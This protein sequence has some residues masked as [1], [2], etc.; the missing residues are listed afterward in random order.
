MPFDYDAIRDTIETRWRRY[1]Y[2]ALLPEER[3]YL[4]VWWLQAEASNGSLHQYFDNSTG[5]AALDTLNALRRRN[6]PSAASVL[7]DSIEI[8]SDG[9][10]PTD[11]LKRQA[12]INALESPYDKFAALTDRLFEQSEDVT[13]LAIDRVGVAYARESINVAEPSA[14]KPMR[15][16]A[17]AL[18]LALGVLAIIAIVVLL[19]SP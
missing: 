5:D 6:A 8:V 2:D 18:L 9:D 14:S 10:Y 11:R 17:T 13:S 19:F 7:S 3:D 16:I 1:G 12:A 15:A 4:L